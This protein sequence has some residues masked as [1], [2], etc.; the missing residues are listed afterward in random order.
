[1]PCVATVCWATVRQVLVIGLNW[2]G[3]TLKWRYFFHWLLSE[4]WT[5]VM[6]W[7]QTFLP[8]FTWLKKNKVQTDLI[9]FWRPCQECIE[10]SKSFLSPVKRRNVPWPP[11]LNN[12]RDR[13][14]ARWVSESHYSAWL[15]NFYS[16]LSLTKD[17]QISIV[18][19]M[20][21]I[22]WARDVN[23]PCQF[24]STRV[25]S[26]VPSRNITPRK[27]LAC[28]SKILIFGH[29]NWTLC[30][31]NLTKRMFF[32]SF[33]IFF[34]FKW[35]SVQGRSVIHSFQIEMPVCQSFIHWINISRRGR[36]PGN[37]SHSLTP[38]ISVP[39][40]QGML[41]YTKTRILQPKTE[42]KWYPYI[43]LEHWRNCHFAEFNLD[44]GASRFFFF[45]KDIHQVKFFQHTN[46][47][48]D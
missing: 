14:W 4:K 2:T 37:N 41:R 16:H 3:F 47:I 25:L 36:W 26:L 48:L 43:D 17:Q 40:T 13:G 27:I 34:F 23:A 21:E 8:I 38:F 44:T 42:R 15:I 28:H 19:R 1:M 20:C 30:Q 22:K 9:Q 12:G 31:K 29:L 5:F 39:V 10:L 18:W 6:F 11:S 33:F 45:F 24:P 7:G 46:W 32:S 35:C